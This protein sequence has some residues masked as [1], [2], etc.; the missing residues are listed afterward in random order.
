MRLDCPSYDIDISV[1]LLPAI[2]NLSQDMTHVVQ[3]ASGHMS[4][5]LT[6]VR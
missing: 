2:S 5:Y 3:S 6:L 1:L 4:Y